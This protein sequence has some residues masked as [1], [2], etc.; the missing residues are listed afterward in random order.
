MNI[1]KLK[2]LISAG[3]YNIAN[4]ARKLGCSYH[5]LFRAISNDPGLRELIDYNRMGKADDVREALLQRALQG[6]VPAI[7]VWLES[8]GRLASKVVFDVNNKHEGEITIQ[9]KSLGE[10]TDAQLSR[11]ND[12]F[13][14]LANAN[15][16]SS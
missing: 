12:I 15:N 2:A 11:I 13:D 7:K 16:E 5:Q 1:K 8:E 4:I 14:E 3:E 9:G 6:D 10:L